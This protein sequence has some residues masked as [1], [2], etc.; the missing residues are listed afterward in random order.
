MLQTFST[1]K[2]F[3]MLILAAAWIPPLVF[4]QEFP[5]L[6]A[7]VGSTI[8]ITGCVHAGKPSGQVV[9]VGVIE[10]SVDGTPAP[11]QSIYWLNST[12][13]LKPLVG[14]VVD[15]TGT[16]VKREPELGGV[17]VEVRPEEQ[18]ESVKIDTDWKTA[19]TKAY[20]GAADK[21]TVEVTRPVYRLKVQTVAPSA[22]QTAGAACQ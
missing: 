15:I 5:S 1:N 21:Q 8:V 22:G 6:D 2:Q 16:V 7:K 13:Q 10:R 18:T 4:A 20:A 19:T 3:A 9:L 12:K 11:F 14:Q 17:K